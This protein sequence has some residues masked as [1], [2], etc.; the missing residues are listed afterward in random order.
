MASK[1]MIDR[2]ISVSE[3]V[4]KLSIQSKL[5]FTWM[6]PHADDIGLL[7]GSLLT[8]K[9]VVVPLLEMSAEG[10]QDCIKEIKS[11]K[12]ISDFE[13]EGQNYLRIDKFNLI[14]GLRKD[15]Q[16]HTILPISYEKRS[17]STWKKLYKIIGNTSIT[18]RNECVTP[19]NETCGTV[20]EGKLGEVKGSEEKKDTPK[21]SPKGEKEYLI[22]TSLQKAVCGWKVITGNKKDD[23]SWDRMHWGRTARSA[24]TL[25]EY[26]NG[27]WKQAVNCMQDIYEGLKKKD[28][29]CTIET[30][31]KRSAEWK[32]QNIEN[33]GN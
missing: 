33:T 4:S 9:A 16:P 19:R 18:K 22:E 3:Q 7:P 29:D 12:L 6:I 32:Q 26:F 17:S 20:E 1:R 25:L 24:A 27:D 15:I 11:Q 30:I 8:L 31:C 28:L 21:S 14:Q 2:K 5:I 13:Y 10:F 23:R